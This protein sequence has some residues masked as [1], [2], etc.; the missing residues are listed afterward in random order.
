MQAA[1]RW[2]LKEW[3]V[4]CRAL[5]TGRQSILLRKGGIDEGPDG[6]RI[7]HQ[8]FWLLPTR[9]HEGIE[10]LAPGSELLLADA[11]ADEPA[12]GTFRIA[13][14]GV[15]DEVREIRDPAELDRLAPLQ[16][17]SAETLRKRFHYR[18]PGISLIVV[19]AYR[20]SESRMGIETPELAGCRS[21]AELPAELPTGGGEPVLSDEGFAAVRESVWRA[22]GE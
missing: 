3:A 14:Y 18:Q 8:E 13:V 5:E 12:A 16:I 6:F 21:W 22:G 4:V 15:A 19:R 17:L 11:R 2:A 20:M 1:N 10:S 7:R 9:F